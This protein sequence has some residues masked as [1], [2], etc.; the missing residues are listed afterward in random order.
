[1]VD[2]L[3]TFFGKVNGT[4]T[5]VVDLIEYIEGKKYEHIEKVGYIFENGAYAGW[6]YL[7][8][9]ELLKKLHNIG[10]WSI[11]VSNTK[12]GKITPD[13][14]LIGL[15]NNDNYFGVLSV[16][17]LYKEKEW[18]EYVLKYGF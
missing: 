15:I 10:C 1:M 5:N 8:D 12:D 11:G 16:K 6:K 7:R 3:N 9:S 13:S 14:Q 18:M 2:G 17:G 4:T